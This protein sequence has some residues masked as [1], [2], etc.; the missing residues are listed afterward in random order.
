MTQTFSGVPKA[1][2]WR[3]ATRLQSQLSAPPLWHR[4]WGKSRQKGTSYSVHRSHDLLLDSQPRGCCAA[5]M[6]WRGVG[7][8]VQRSPLEKGSGQPGPRP[9][10]AVT[11]LCDPGNIPCPLWACEYRPLEGRGQSW[12]VLLM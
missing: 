10:S 4:L 7:V 11:L 5:L 2:I 6:S 1:L 12:K 8:E 3:V 9:G